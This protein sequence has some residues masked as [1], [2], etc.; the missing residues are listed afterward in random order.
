MEEITLESLIFLLSLNCP[1]INHEA[2][3]VIAHAEYRPEVR[4]VKQSRVAQ[5]QYLDATLS[6]D[7]TGSSC[8]M[9][10]DDR[11]A[12]KIEY[13]EVNKDLRS[14]MLGSICGEIA[15]D[16]VANQIAQKILDTGTNPTWHMSVGGTKGY[17]DF[18]DS[19]Y[20]TLSSHGLGCEYR[21]H[22]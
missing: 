2:T 1:G 9:Q 15:F 16:N 17:L 22:F 10:L 3:L 14:A 19:S 4:V 13:M 20:I 18:S 8:A 5:V 12:G 7:M 21:E 11:A 6:I